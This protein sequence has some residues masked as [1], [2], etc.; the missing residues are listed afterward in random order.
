MDQE[1]ESFNIWLK[2]CGGTM[3]FIHVAEKSSTVHVLFLGICYM[4]IMWCSSPH[5]DGDPLMINYILFKVGHPLCEGV[6]TIIDILIYVQH[7]S[8]F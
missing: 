6:D 5:M 7:Y 4:Y 3:Y 1:N 8:Y 2:T